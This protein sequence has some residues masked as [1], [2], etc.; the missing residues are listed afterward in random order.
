MKK[1]NIIVF[2]LLLL[3][4]TCGT[5]L[6]AINFQG[7]QVE[8]TVTLWEAKDKAYMAATVPCYKYTDS[9]WMSSTSLVTMN[10]QERQTPE[11]ALLKQS[12]DS[13]AEIKLLSRYGSGSKGPYVFTFK[14]REK[15]KGQAEKDREASSVM[16][17]WDGQQYRL[18]MS[19]F[20]DIFLA[21]CVKADPVA[22]KTTIMP[23]SSPKI[24]DLK[25]LQYYS[26][27]LEKDI[28]LYMNTTY[29]GYENVEDAYASALCLSNYFSLVE[30]DDVSEFAKKGLST[31][32]LASFDSSLSIAS[33][34]FMNGKMILRGSVLLYSIDFGEGCVTYFMDQNKPVPEMTPTIRF[35][36][37]ETGFWRL[38]P[39][40]TPPGELTQKSTWIVLMLLS[41]EFFEQI[42]QELYKTPPLVQLKE[43]LYFDPVQISSNEFQ[44][45][46][47]MSWASTNDMDC[48]FK[49]YERIEEE[50]PLDE[51]EQEKASVSTNAVDQVVDTDVETENTDEKKVDVSQQ[52]ADADESGEAELA[53]ESS[54]EKDKPM[55][56]I[57]V[58]EEL[59]GVEVQTFPAGDYKP[60]FILDANYIPDIDG[61][62]LK[63]VFDE[64][65]GDEGR[66]GK[67]TSAIIQM[68][69]IDD[70]E[71]EEEEEISQRW[72][73]N[74]DS[75]ESVTQ[76]ISEKGKVTDEGT[77]EK[78]LTEETKTKSAEE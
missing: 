52:D 59:L 47:F 23:P 18:S 40:F 64:V 17:L 65:L 31:D 78:E 75:E 42:R 4:I 46:I 6:A 43:S 51:S 66:L 21:Y 32:T 33:N 73:G 77:S 10:K 62:E 2:S 7:Q 5:L 48:V 45:P 71:E 39:Q 70:D 36:R 74:A 25:K 8:H 16:L 49:I 69:F 55:T 44:I 50:I 53:G 58:R 63:I 11:Y 35:F 37:K 41:D 34:F 14:A 13:D 29:V 15:G 57:I 38:A 60:S 20:S 68:P 1:R 54:K 3:H 12:G 26:T 67:R 56:K 19:F 30:A 27:A 24:R 28:P 61:A 72:K 22:Y 9:G 76:E